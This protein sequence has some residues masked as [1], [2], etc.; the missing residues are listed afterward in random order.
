MFQIRQ[1]LLAMR[2]G[3]N[4]RAEVRTLVYN[5]ISKN[6]IHMLCRE[7]S[8][9]GIIAIILLHLMNFQRPYFS[10]I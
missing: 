2:R 10:F 4:L 5:Y 6:Y 3:E 8:I 1:V 9:R 7:I